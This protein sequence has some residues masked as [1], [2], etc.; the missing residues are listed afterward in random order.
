[1]FEANCKQ[2]KKETSALQYGI[3]PTIEIHFQQLCSDTHM[4]GQFSRV[5][6]MLGQWISEICKKETGLKK[7]HVKC[8]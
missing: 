8:H 4:T 3:K 7:E 6:C 1:M 5:C 2:M